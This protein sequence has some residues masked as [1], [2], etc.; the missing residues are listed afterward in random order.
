MTE[1]EGAWS[2]GDRD[3][4]E[5]LGRDQEPFSQTWSLR[6]WIWKFLLVREDGEGQV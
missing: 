1:R 3:I 2:K 4:G 5:M 6:E